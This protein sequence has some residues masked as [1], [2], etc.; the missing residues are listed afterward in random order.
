M[1]TVVFAA[2]VLVVEAVGAFGFAVVGAV[3]AAERA[4][5]HRDHQ[6]DE[7]RERPEHDE[8]RTP[9]TRPLQLPALTDVVGC[10]HGVEDGSRVRR[11]DADRARIAGTHP[12][13]VVARSRPRERPADATRDGLG[14]AEIALGHVQHAVAE[15]AQRTVAN[16]VPAAGAGRPVNAGAVDL[17]DEPLRPAT[18]GPP[19]TVRRSTR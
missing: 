1:R 17:D 4:R 8:A 15:P 5:E 12:H 2:D 10:G 16:G 7:H 19:P 13:H 18:A 14:C 11:L 6:P 9:P 3:P